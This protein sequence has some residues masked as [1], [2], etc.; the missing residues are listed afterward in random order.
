MDA[1]TSLANIMASST[2]ETT[3][4]E[5]LHNKKPTVYANL[6][7]FGRIGYVTKRN[8]IK[9]KIS[10]KSV[11]CICLGHAKNHATDVYRMNNTETKSTQFSRDIKWADWYG[12]P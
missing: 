4:Y 3:A 10:E 6:Q 8:K 1:S 2:H 11:K 7:P 12:G 9:K 5:M